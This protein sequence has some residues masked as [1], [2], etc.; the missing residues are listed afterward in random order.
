MNFDNQLDVPVDVVALKDLAARSDVL[1]F[2]LPLEQ[3]PVFG[4]ISSFVTIHGFQM[5][6]SP[7]RRLNVRASLV[8][9]SSTRGRLM[10][11]V[12]EGFRPPKNRVSAGSIPVTRSTRE[13]CCS[14]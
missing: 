1:S 10:V 11:Y 3:P 7:N 12:G 4:T 8:A 9:V 14:T 13:R 6:P 5:R 2:M